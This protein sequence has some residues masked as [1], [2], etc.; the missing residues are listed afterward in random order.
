[1]KGRCPAVLIALFL[2]IGPACKAWAGGGRLEFT[3]G[4]T[5]SKVAGGVKVSFA[6]SAPT[7]VEVALL[8]T[9]GKVVRH[10]AAGVLGGRLPPPAPLKPGLKQT[11]LWDGADDAGEPVERGTYTVRVRAG[12]G[13]KF[14]RVI[15]GSPYTG[16]VVQMPYRAPVNG[17]AVD[18]EGNLYVK[19]YSTV[20]SHG[21]T[22]LWPWHVRKF[23]KTGRYIKTVLPYLPSTNPA[24]ASGFTLLDTGDGAFTPANQNSLYPVFY[25]FGNEI[26]SKLVDGSMLFVHSETRELNFLKLDGSNEL[27]TV[28]MWSAEAKLNCP[29]WLDIQVAISPDGRYAYYSNVA[30]TAYDGKKPADIDSNWPQGRIYRQDLTKPGSDPQVFYDLKLPDWEKAEYWMPSAWDKKTAAAGIACGAKGNVYVCGLVSQEVVE[31]SPQGKKLGAVKIPWPDKIMVNFKTDDLYVISRKVSRGYLPAAKL[32]KISGGGEDAKVVAELQ[33]TGTIGGAYTLDESGKVPVLWLAGGTRQGEK[34]LRIED[35][36]DDLVITGDDFL[37]RDRSALTF[38]GYM[39]VDP[40]AELVYVTRSGGTVW[41]YEGRTGRGGPLE[42]QAVDLAVGPRGMV[43]TW[44]ISG[45]YHGPVARFDRNLD[46]ARIPALGRHTFGYLYGRAGRGSSVCG[47]DVDVHGNVYATYGGNDC[48]VRVYDANGA[49]VQYQR[50][51][52]LKGDKGVEEVPAVVTH[53]SGYGGSIRVDNKGNIYI[54]QKGLPEGFEFPKGYESDPAYRN[55]VGTILKFGPEGGGRAK[56][57]HSM[58]GFAGVLKVYPDC[59]PLSRWRCAGSCCC[60]KPRFDVDG[61]GRLYI[62]NGITFSVSVRDNAGNEIVKFG[63]Y[64]NFDCQGPESSEPKPEIPLGWPVAAGASDGHIYVGDCLNHRVVR[65][66]KTFVL[67]ETCSA[68]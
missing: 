56:V 48:H 17:L 53:V 5:A 11:L 58:E 32:Y 13:V 64:G 29:G 66:D 10:L 30:G 52:E 47:L 19:M 34:L 54:L 16:T 14:G 51:V 36:G 33:L 41:R 57:V 42:I 1:M 61:Y 8:D 63:H 50:K 68:R 60:T 4:P 12:T 35:H 67:E 31:L 37:N 45:S 3:S 62:P 40:Q 23:D 2:T 55:A 28:K 6:L 49:L 46:P 21:N 20:G 43:Y 25:L 65:V 7:D 38:V 59:G 39:D 27:K 18:G 24:K 22:G 15:G 9:N 44:G 26:Y